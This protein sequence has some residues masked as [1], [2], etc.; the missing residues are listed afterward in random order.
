MNN[1][2]CKDALYH[3]WTNVS[4]EDVSNY[5]R[6]YYARNKLDW[7]KRKE[8][9]KNPIFNH[10]ASNNGL[11]SGEGE[12]FGLK[13]LVQGVKKTY[14]IVKDT[15]EAG[16]NFINK[17]IDWR[18]EVHKERGDTSTTIPA[19]IK[20]GFDWLKKYFGNS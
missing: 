2:H 9:R 16:K 10:G 8:K 5:N 18:R 1:R 6:D 12:S 11:Q 13:N 14:E 20:S 15:I 7:I 19:M 4:K 3:A 17:V